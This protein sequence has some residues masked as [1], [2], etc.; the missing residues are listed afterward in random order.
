M[1]RYFHSTFSIITNHHVPVYH[2]L[3]TTVTLLRNIYTCIHTYS[4]YLSFP[5]SDVNSQN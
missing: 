2:K 4:T 5:C 1:I 3:I